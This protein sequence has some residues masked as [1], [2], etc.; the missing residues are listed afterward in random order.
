MR[1]GAYEKKLLCLLT[2]Q[3]VE[4]L[5]GE[6]DGGKGQLG[7]GKGGDAKML[8]EDGG[9]GSVACRDD[10]TLRGDD[11]DGEREALGRG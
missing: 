4:G 5:E 2:G 3:K 6:G 10:E 9:D 11:D 1:E 7:G 8:V